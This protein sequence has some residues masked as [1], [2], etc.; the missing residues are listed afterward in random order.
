MCTMLLKK[1]DTSGLGARFS[2]VLICIV[3][4]LFAFSSDDV[5]ERNEPSFV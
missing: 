2:F 5:K 1:L 4:T 3:G